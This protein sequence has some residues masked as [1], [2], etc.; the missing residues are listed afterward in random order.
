MCLKDPYIQDILSINRLSADPSE[1][2]QR[3]Y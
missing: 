3:E 1:A 2:S